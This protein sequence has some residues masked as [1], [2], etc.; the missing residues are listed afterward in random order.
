MQCRGAD[1]VPTPLV[2]SKTHATGEPERKH[3]IRLAAKGDTRQG[4]N[5][6]AGG[7]GAVLLISIDTY[8]SLVANFKHLLLHSAAQ[9]V[10]RWYV[11]N[12]FGKAVL[13][14]IILCRTNWKVPTILHHLM[15]IHLCFRSVRAYPTDV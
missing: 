1:V 13:C 7:G 14:C 15:S 11:Y 4:C 2:V 5:L 10:G 3:A 6:S 12:A 9:R 8:Q